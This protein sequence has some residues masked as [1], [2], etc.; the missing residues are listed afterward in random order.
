MHHMENKTEE[1]LIKK[2]TLEDA[3]NSNFN[4]W[5]KQFSYTINQSLK[6]V[7]DFRT[8]EEKK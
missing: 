6:F 3:L 1:K 7:R 2:N 8:Q 4:A 5:L